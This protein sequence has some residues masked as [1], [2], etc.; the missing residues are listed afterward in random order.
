MELSIKLNNEEDLLNLTDLLLP[1]NYLN[2]FIYE[3]QDLKILERRFEREMNIRML[4]NQEILRF[5]FS[6]TIKRKISYV[7]VKT[8][9]KESPTFLEL[10]LIVSPYVEETI[11]LLLDSKEIDIE[12]K[13]YQLLNKIELFRNF[14]EFKK[15][16]IIRYILLFFRL[17]LGYLT[18]TIN[19]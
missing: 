12:N 14:S 11:K 2:N 6:Q 15:R 10:L 3:L 16:A 4:D 13:I 9:K 17:L 18:I 19:R 8:I 5:P 7:E 1:L